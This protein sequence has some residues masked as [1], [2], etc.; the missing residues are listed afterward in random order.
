MENKIVFGKLFKVRS[1]KN[2]LPISKNYNNNFITTKLGKL[3]RP[4]VV[5][6]SNDYVYYLSVKSITK[7]NQYKTTNDDRNV[8]IPNINIYGNEAPIGNAI[9]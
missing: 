7:K 2:N 5:F 4:Y 8:I 9:N 1:S 6:Y 3:N